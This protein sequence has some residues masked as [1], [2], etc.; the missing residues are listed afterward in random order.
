MRPRPSGSVAG[1]SQWGAPP[2]PRGAL[3]RAIL[4]RECRAA[5]LVTTIV[6]AVAGAALGRVLADRGLIPNPAAANSIPLQG[7]ASL[8]DFGLWMLARLLP[9]PVALMAGVATV[10]RLAGDSHAPWLL[11]LAAA[12]MER[13][14]YLVAVVVAAATSHLAFYTALM[15]GY[16]TGAATLSDEAGMLAFHFLRNWPGVAALFV[17]TTLFGAACFALTRRRGL[18][19]ALALAGVA[20]PVAVLGWIGVEGMQSASPTVVRLLT[21]LTPPPVWTASAAVLLRHGLYSTVLL[22]LLTRYA[23]RWVARNG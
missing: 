20:G 21:V 3:A 2:V 11:T 16:I 18:A 10:D 19:L 23:P 15:A 22:V 8:G 17:S 5:S 13:G 7:I 4:R 6:L 14:F 9:L 12:G 1:D